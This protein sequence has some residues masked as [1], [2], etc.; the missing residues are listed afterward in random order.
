MVKVAFYIASKGKLYD[1]LVS[2]FTGCK[3]SHVELVVNDVCF[4]SSNRDGGV[5]S[6]VINLSSGKWELI[7]IECISK[8]TIYDFFEATK[9]CK[10]DFFSVIINMLFRIKVD[11]FSSRYHC[12]EWCLT[13]LNKANKE[14]YNT[15]MTIKNFYDLCK[16]LEL[17]YD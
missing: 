13:A 17:K 6:K 11:C 1:K 8:Q 4:S 16:K 10:Y 12:S 14:Y 9:H 5:R 2:L 3:Y 15:N 7:A